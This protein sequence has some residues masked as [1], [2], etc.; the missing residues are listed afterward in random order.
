MERAF[1]GGHG[2]SCHECNGLEVWLVASTES[3]IKLG[4]PMWLAANFRRYQK[5]PR[6]H[7]SVL[8]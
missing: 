5:F 6:H 3:N 2:S 7:F 8:N 4:G 1:G